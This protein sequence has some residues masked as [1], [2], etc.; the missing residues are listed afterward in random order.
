MPKPPPALD[1][2]PWPMKWIVLAIVAC[3]VP[4]TWLTL[5]Y[6]KEGPAYE[7]YQDNK[8]RAQVMRLLD[9]GFRRVEL[10]LDRL[11]DP[12]MPLAASAETQA[13]EGGLPPLLS[14][15]LIDKPPVPSSFA[16]VDAPA[17]SLAGAPYVLLLT[18]Q[19]PDHSERPAVSTLYL[20]G[21]EAVFIVGYDA[22][23][24]DLQARDLTARLR[25]TVPPNTLEPGTYQGT[26]IG[27]LESRRWTFDIH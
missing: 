22:L 10:S 18:A 20:R 13:I 21:Q 16:L 25:L 26:L 7:P 24:G 15:V 9:A 2:K 1:R 14:E 19:Q 27:A 23:P 5:A 4:Y 11:V 12:S 3:L 17:Q 6:R 8:D